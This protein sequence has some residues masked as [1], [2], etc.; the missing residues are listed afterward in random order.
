VAFADFLSVKQLVSACQNNLANKIYQGPAKRGR[1][2]SLYVAL[3]TSNLWG[4]LHVVVCVSS[5]AREPQ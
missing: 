2:K 1:R 3:E 4:S 5:V